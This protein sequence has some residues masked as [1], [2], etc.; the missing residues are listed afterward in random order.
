[1]QLKLTKNDVKEEITMAE[2]FNLDRDSGFKT[3]QEIVEKIESIAI[4]ANEFRGEVKDVYAKSDLAFLKRVSKSLGE[5]EAAS[6][7]IIENFVGIEDALATYN[8]QPDEGIRNTILFKEGA[9]YGRK[10]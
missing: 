2:K 8:T 7:K 9:I 1:M 3:I 5:L 4:T 6:S 10:S